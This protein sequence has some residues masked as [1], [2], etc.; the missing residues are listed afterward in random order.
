MGPNNVKIRGTYLVNE[1]T[2]IDPNMQMRLAPTSNVNLDEKSLLVIL[3]H[4]CI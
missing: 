3:V 1:A 4:Q 2:F